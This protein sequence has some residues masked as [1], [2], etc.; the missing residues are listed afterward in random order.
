MDHLLFAASEG[1]SLLQYLGGIWAFMQGIIGLGIVIFVHELGHFLVAK[2]CGVRCDKFYVGFDVPI[3]IGPWTISALWKKQW[4]ETEYGIGT[5]PLGGYV[6]MLGQDD[7]P[8]NAEDESASTMIETVDEEG[9]AKEVVNPRSYT[10]KSVPQRMAIISAGVVFNL[11]FGVIFAA[12]AYNMGVPYIPAQISWVQP[13]SPAWEAG[14]NPGDEIVGLNSEGKVRKDLRFDKDMTLQIIMNGDDKAMP[15]VVKRTNGEQEVIDI[16]PKNTYKDAQRPTIGVAPM[17][18]TKMV[19]APKLMGMIFGSEVADKLKPGD[20]LVGINDEPIANFLDYQ[21]YVANH[22]YDALKLKLERKIDTDSEATED[23]EVEIPTVPYRET[24]LIMEIS[25]VR[26]IRSGSPAEKAGIKVGDKLVSLNGEP[27]GDGYTLP[28]RETKWAGETIEVVIE[29]DGKEETKSIETVVPQGFSS[30]YMPGYEIGLQTLG[31]TFDLTTTIAEVLPESSAAEA[32]LAA[33]DEVLI[34]GFQGT[35][36]A[37]KEVNEEMKIGVK[38][39]KVK[40]DEIAWQAVQ[41]TL[42]VAHPDTD[43]V[44]TVKKKDTGSP[45][46]VSV[47]STPS[48]T[49]MLQSRY[50]RFDVEEKI[51][52]ATSLGDSL[53]LGVRE[54]GEGMNQVI[55]VL[56][57]IFSGEMQISGL[58]GPGTILYVATAES[59]RG[60]SRLLTFLTLISANLAVVNFLPIPVLDGGHM[61]FL[62]YEGIRGKAMNEKWMLRLTY[63]GLAMVLT[64][65][66]TV[67]FLDINRFFPWG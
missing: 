7:N 20:N 18:T 43:M 37:A 64:L 15:F 52:Y 28:S 53:Y 60:I 55:V 27:L 51:Q 12:I 50:L 48:K 61:M 32:G 17:Y 19:V 6:K 67:I 65:M 49:D 25:P 42:Q 3:T 9:N 45:E 14:L 47:G 46:N 24:G 36:D 16:V 4:G 1:P 31:L 56:R 54:V 23:V 26:G 34:V 2:A 41:W 38:D 5:I 59:S 62:L 33:G 66:V 22:P 29:R 13:G 57:K 40:T 8:N 35:T 63:L 11:I 30:E 58:G 10:A 21:K 44:L 39:V